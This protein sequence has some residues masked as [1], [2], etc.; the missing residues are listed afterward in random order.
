[1]YVCMYVGIRVGGSRIVRC[2]YVNWSVPASS[3]ADGVMQ[4][5]GGLVHELAGGVSTA[6]VHPVRGVRGSSYS[7]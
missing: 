2:C 6:L 4:G 3:Y 7:K 5:L 1:M